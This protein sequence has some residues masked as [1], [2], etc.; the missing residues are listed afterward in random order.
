MDNVDNDLEKPSY[1]GRVDNNQALKIY[2]VCADMRCG[3]RGHKRHSPELHRI[4][5]DPQD[6]LQSV[7]I[8]FCEI[9]REL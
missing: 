5:R 2:S 3:V 8:M 7:Q 6:Y 1:E 4:Q 9:E